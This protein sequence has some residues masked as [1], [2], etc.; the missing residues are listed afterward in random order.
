MDFDFG[1][2]NILQTGKK[3]LVDCPLARGMGVTAI[4]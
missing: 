1:E 2:A 4:L 3:V